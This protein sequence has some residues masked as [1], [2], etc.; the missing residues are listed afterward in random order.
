MN[1]RMGRAGIWA[2][3]SLRPRGEG[4]YMVQP[5][6]QGIFDRHSLWMGKGESIVL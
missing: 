5:G 1:W 3:A 6:E 2:G 4:V